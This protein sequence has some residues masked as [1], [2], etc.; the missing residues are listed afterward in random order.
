MRFK[1][2]AKRILFNICEKFVQDYKKDLSQSKMS[3]E[4]LRCE[5]NARIH[6]IQENNSRNIVFN[7][8]IPEVIKET[9]EKDNY[10]ISES[11]AFHKAVQ[12]FVEQKNNGEIDFL[13]R[14]VT[15]SAE[16]K[17]E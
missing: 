15:K 10:L 1:K 2:V 6:Q 11:Q 16:V 7:K 13:N 5:L 17:G 9:L 8:L 14:Y 3:D 4:R 12:R